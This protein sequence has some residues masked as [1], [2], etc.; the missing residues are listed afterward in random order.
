MDGIIMLLIGMSVF[1]SPKSDSHDL[2]LDFKDVSIATKIFV[3]VVLGFSVWTIA[4]CSFWTNTITIDSVRDFVDNT[5]L[6]IGAFFLTLSIL[7]ENII[8]KPIVHI[9]SKKIRT[10]LYYL[11][12]AIIVMIA[13]YQFMYL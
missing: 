8:K 5:W 6:G 10:V 7:L 2:L 3:F 4:S 1:V 9:K 12:M 13:I 11:V